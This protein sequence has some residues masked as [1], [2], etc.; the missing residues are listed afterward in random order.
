[1]NQLFAYVESW[2]DRYGDDY[3]VGIRED[4]LE[5]LSHEPLEEEGFEL[6]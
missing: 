2:K 4:P 1:M 5:V 3:I 6:L